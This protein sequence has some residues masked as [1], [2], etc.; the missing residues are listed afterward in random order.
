[1]LR[2]QILKGAKPGDLPIGRP[3]KFELV[4]NMKTAKAL[5]LAIPQ[6]LLLRADEVIVRARVFV[7]LLLV[8]SSMC[9]QNGRR[10]RTSGSGTFVLR[11]GTANTKLGAENIHA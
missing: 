10:T 9:K 11:E 7:C 1:L 2:R 5:D 3:T 4:I 8:A 6:A